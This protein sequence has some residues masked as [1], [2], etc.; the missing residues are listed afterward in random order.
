MITLS[1]DISI[2][3]SQALYDTYISTLQFHQLTCSCG[4]CGSLNIHGYYTRKLKSY[5][6]KVHLNICRVKCSSCGKTHALLP[7]SIVPYSQTPLTTQVDIISTY[8]NN[9]DFAPIM[10]NASS[11]DESNIRS[12]IRS[13]KHHWKQK[14]LSQTIPLEKNL[15]FIQKC[16]CSFSRQFMQIKYTS[17][18]LF[19][20]PT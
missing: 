18:S 14:L 13:F 6:I 20:L 1:V 19:L 2:P 3:I 17:N 12:I 4:R 8:E 11:I 10:E 15:S 7:S 5:A 16:F 9:A